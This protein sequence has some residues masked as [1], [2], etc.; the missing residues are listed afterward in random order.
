MAQRDEKHYKYEL[1]DY[2]TRRHGTL[3]AHM[4][5]HP[6]EKLFK[7][8]LC[9]NSFSDRSNLKVHKGSLSGEKLFK[10]ELCD[11][12]F[13]QRCNLNRHILLHNE[14][15]KDPYDGMCIVSFRS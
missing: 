8:E 12:I 2:G 14:D 6:G 3:T 5:M 10:C 4:R 1:C 9:H 15:N 11:N 13:C 7:C